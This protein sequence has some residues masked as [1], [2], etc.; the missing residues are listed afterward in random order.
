MKPAAAGGGSLTTDR[1]PL[2]KHRLRVKSCEELTHFS[3]SH[4]ACGPVLC[5]KT[6][7][8]RLVRLLNEGCQH[9]MAAGR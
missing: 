2:S 4:F 6:V 1:V 8:Q 3:A 9:V 5:G 7:G